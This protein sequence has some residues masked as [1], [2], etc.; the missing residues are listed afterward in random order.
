MNLREVDKQSN[1]AAARDRRRRATTNV[2]GLI[3]TCRGESQKIAWKVRAFQHPKS[4]PL[5]FCGK[6]FLLFEQNNGMKGGESS[7]S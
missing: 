3:S 4:L 6:D 7:A 1:T 5:V 2:A